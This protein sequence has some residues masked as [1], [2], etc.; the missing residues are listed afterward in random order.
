MM[1]KN[2]NK[3]HILDFGCVEEMSWH[4]NKPAEA[5][6]ENGCSESLIRI[7]RRAIVL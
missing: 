3:A 2:W 4:F 7:V 5:P 1:V 6:W